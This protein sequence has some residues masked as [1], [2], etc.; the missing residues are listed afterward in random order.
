[1]P[2][3]LASRPSPLSIGVRGSGL[4]RFHARLTPPTGQSR[5][6]KLRAGLVASRTLPLVWPSSHLTDTLY[7]HRPEERPVAAAYQPAVQYQMLIPMI[8]SQFRPRSLLVKQ[9]R[10]LAQCHAVPHG[11]HPCT[12][13]VPYEYPPVPHSATPPDLTSR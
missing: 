6:W 13:P 11:Y 12:C 1:M 4:G 10:R 7:Q 3:G 2:A 8:P 9:H 5:G